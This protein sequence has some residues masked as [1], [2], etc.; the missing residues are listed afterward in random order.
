MVCRVKAAM[1]NFNK[2]DF[3]VNK[4]TCSLVY[5]GMNRL[6]NIGSLDLKKGL[7]CFLLGMAEQVFDNDLHLET[8][9]IVSLSCQSDPTTW[10]KGFNYM[11][12]L[13]D[14]SI[15]HIILLWSYIL[16][17]ISYNNAGTEEKVLQNRPL[18]RNQNAKRIN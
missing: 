13:Q 9:L 8:F 2:G 15:Y 10:P 7:H 1:R 18:L 14:D 5:S 11:N 17:I 4:I 16:I 6:G 3:C 12:I